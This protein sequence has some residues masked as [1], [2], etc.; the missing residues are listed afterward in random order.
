MLLLHSRMSYKHHEIVSES[1]LSFPL[2]FP[3][4]F[5]LHP[6]LAG[7]T[8]ASCHCVGRQANRMWPLLPSPAPPQQEC[9]FISPLGAVR[10]FF[11]HILSKNLSAAAGF[12]NSYRA[13][14]KT[15]R[16]YIQELHPG[17][18][19][20]PTSSWPLTS[21]TAG[22]RGSRNDTEPRQ[23]ACRPSHDCEIP[24][25]VL[26]ASHGKRETLASG[27]DTYQCTAASS[28]TC[29]QPRRQCRF[30]GSS[31]GWTHIRLCSFGS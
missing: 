16:S 29:I 19:E 31:R 25:H 9:R 5:P 18:P 28:C 12:P 21:S 23:E 13:K 24:S 27:G 15:S 6:D 11:P 4:I 3:H 1:S 22:T 8:A 7:S 2:P 17:A 10:F 20:E 14:R 30:P 26:P